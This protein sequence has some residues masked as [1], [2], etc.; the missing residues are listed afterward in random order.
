MSLINDALKRASEAEKRRAGIRPGGRRGPKGPEALGPPLKPAKKRGPSLFS[1]PSFWMAMFT[2]TL[3]VVSGAFFYSWW[4]VKPAPFK[5]HVPPGMDPLEAMIIP[6][7]PKE[8][9][10]E[11]GLLVVDADGKVKTKQDEKAAV[12]NDVPVV[13]TASNTVAAVTVETNVPMVK[14]RPS[15]AP[16]VDTNAPT[17][18]KATGLPA[19]APEGHQGEVV[20]TNTDEPKNGDVP[21]EPKSDEP[22]PTVELKGIMI[23]ADK[24][25]AIVN[26]K[27][28]RIGDRVGNAE[29]IEIG[30]DYV[31]FKRGTEVRQFYL[32]N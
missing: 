32:L 16:G 30:S 26:G 20:V 17:I 31:K 14:P 23:M 27:F 25:T 29:L 18:V 3:V 15:K 2:I 9:A 11:T 22:F 4:R 21:D 1:R 5:L 28:M 10:P 13:A 19:M 6:T 24:A 7:K 8:K 12:T